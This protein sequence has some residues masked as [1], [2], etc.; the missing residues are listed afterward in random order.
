MKELGINHLS[1]QW[2]VIKA[3]IKQNIFVTTRQS[4]VPVPYGGFHS[5]IVVQDQKTYQLNVSFIA[6]STW[7]TTEVVQLISV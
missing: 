3:K 6:V 7:S 4:P 1:V 2:L 5:S